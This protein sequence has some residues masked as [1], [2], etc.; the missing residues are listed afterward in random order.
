MTNTSTKRHGV[1]D[2]RGRFHPIGPEGKGGLS[3]AIATAAANADRTGR[4]HDVVETDTVTGE[5]RSVPI[6]TRRPLAGNQVSRS[7]SGGR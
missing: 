4:I 2:H 3:S 5:T 7:T 1:R 6:G